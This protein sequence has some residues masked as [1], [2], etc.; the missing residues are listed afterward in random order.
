M[1][2]PDY[3]D[4]KNAVDAGNG[5]PLDEFIAANEPAGREAETE[6]RKEL[7]GLVDFLQGDYEE[8]EKVEVY[9]HGDWY[10][11]KIVEFG[12]YACVELFGTGNQFFELKE[13]VRKLK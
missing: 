7:Q 6:F 3:N 11:T 5:T 9:T 4:A 8:G 10:K 13:Q 12:I 2:L 1:K